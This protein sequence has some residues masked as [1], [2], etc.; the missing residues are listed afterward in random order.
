MSGLGSKTHSLSKANIQS[1]DKK[2]SG[3]NSNF[4]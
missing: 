4:V 2:Q 3:S 1:G